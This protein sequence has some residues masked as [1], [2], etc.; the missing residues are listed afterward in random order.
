MQAMVRFGLFSLLYN[1]CSMYI[2]DSKNSMS[3]VAISKVTGRYKEENKSD[4]LSSY[5]ELKTKIW[6]YVCKRAY[7]HST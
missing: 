4:L 2:F 5:S 7:I 3:I 6:V 1:V